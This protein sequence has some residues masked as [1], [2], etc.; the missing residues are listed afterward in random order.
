M[1]AGQVL[2]VVED[3]DSLREAM[4]RLLVAA[5]FDATSYGSG[6]ALLEAG[7]AASA[8][9]LVVDIRLPG[10]SGFELLRRLGAAGVSRPAILISAFGGRN[11]RADSLAVGAAE[12]LAKPFL[13]STLIEAV[14]RH[15]PVRGP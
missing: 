14:G 8:E 5:G 9:C 13:G 3:D 15:L 12:Y 10:I 11:D 6:E 7:T 1:A 4:Q 2:I